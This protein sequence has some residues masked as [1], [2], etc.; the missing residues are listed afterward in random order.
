[1]GGKDNYAADRKAGDAALEAYP[2]IA[3]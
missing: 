1:M 3:G 2:Y